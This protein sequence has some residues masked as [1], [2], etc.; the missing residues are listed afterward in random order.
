[1]L[2]LAHS[3]QE[4]VIGL[5]AGNRQKHSQA[6]N[7][8]TSPNNYAP[9]DFLARIKLIKLGFINLDLYLFELGHYLL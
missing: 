7:D 3:M 4:I 9:V 1:V 8:N 6:Y 2:Q 5:H